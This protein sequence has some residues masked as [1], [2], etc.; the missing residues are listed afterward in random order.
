M[1]QTSE[2]AVIGAGPY[3]LSIATHLRARGI[4]VR[5]FGSPMHSWRTHMPAGMFLKSEGFASN[6]HDPDGRFTLKGFCATHGFAYNDTGFA[7]PL[8]TFT[9]YGLAFQRQLVPDLEDQSVAALDRSP[10]GFVLRLEGGE[11]VAARRVVVAVGI[12]YFPHVPTNLADLPRDFLSHS[13]DHHDLSRF[14][15]RDV[16][17]IGGGAS[18]LD[19]MAALYEV[20]AEV[21]LVARRSRLVWTAQASRAL[22][23]RWY[24]K[25]GLG[26]GLRNRFYAYAP[27]LFHG[28]PPQTRLQILRTWLG[29]SG[30]WPVKDRVERMPLLLGYTP[31]SA[32]V[33]DGR[34]E[35]RVV[36]PDG[37]K[38]EIPTHHII[39]A[40]GY[41]VDLRRVVFLSDDLRAQLRSVGYAPTLSPDFQSSVPGLYFVGLASAL[42]FGPVMRFVLGA[43]YT[44]RRL[45]RH[46]ATPMA[47]R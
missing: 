28:M 29:P 42:A 32:E 11:S 35:L 30:A 1:T 4:E 19:L 27:M 8:D 22:W 14:K 43:R 36:G 10:Y 9:A 18:A 40:T 38:R 2:V 37:E 47:R 34:A 39:A 12:D 41:R 7:I 23:K 46:L 6:L 17:V 31:R 44:A 15:G 16:T 5:I 21:R 24:P 20:G 25:C 13:S 3:G 45:A 33:R 26:P